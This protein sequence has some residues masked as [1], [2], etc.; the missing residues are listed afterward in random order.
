MPRVFIRK[1]VELLYPKYSNKCPSTYPEPSLT[2]VEQNGSARRDSGVPIVA[3]HSAPNCKGISTRI[4]HL[5][6]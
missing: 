3:G 5:I 1:G 6:N 2:A 4:A